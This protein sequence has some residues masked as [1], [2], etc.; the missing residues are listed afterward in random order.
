MHSDDSPPDVDEQTD[1]SSLARVYAAARASL[2]QPVTPSVAQQPIEI[3]QLSS[4]LRRVEL[5]TPTLPPATHTGC[6]VIGPTHGPGEICLVDPG[7]PYQDQQTA[8]DR[9]LAQEQAQGRTLRCV[10][11][12]HHHGDHVGGAAHLAAQGTPIWAHGGTRD[13]VAKRVEVSRCLDD[14]ARFLIADIAVHAIW[15]PGHARGHLCFAIEGLDGVE[16]LDI[17]AG[18]MVAGVGTILIDPDEGTMVDYLASLAKLEAFGASRLHPA[19]GPV[20]V[21]GVQRLQQYRAHR[22]MRENRIVAALAGSQPATTADLVALAYADTPRLL[23]PLAQRSLL[24]HLGKL[25]AEGRAID[26]PTGVWRAA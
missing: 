8:L 7:S 3:I 12:T 6:Y 23:W 18:D 17:I 25:Q 14:G 10:L 16:G 22:L 5:R 4:T 26:G 15:T 1:D 2:P 21:D 9:W 19:H 20:I 13:L 24:A 11:L